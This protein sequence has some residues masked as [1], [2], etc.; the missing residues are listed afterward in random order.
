MGTAW[1]VWIS[2]KGPFARSVQLSVPFPFQLRY[3]L[4][5]RVNRQTEAPN[6]NWN[7]ARWVSPKL[8]YRLSVTWSCKQTSP[9]RPHFSRDSRRIHVKRCRK[10]TILLLFLLTLIVVF[11]AYGTWT[12]LHIQKH[13]SLHSWTLDVSHGSTTCQDAGIL[14]SFTHLLYV[15]Y[16]IL[17]IFN[18]PSPVAQQPLVGQGFH[19][20]VASRSRSDTPHSR[21]TPL[22]EWSARRKDLYL[23]TL[24]TQE[25]DIH[26]P[27]GFEFT[28]PAS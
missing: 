21:R 27:G 4:N 12:F 14:P 28:I 6:W 18:S 15:F 8:S 7:V 24:N 2:Q 23:T 13:T 25:K 11:H 16:N 3:Q 17:K 1:Y 22:D 19:I 5:V 20:I 9:F 26:A 10:I